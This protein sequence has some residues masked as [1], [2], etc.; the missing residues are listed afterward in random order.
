MSIDLDT[1]MQARQRVESLRA[2]LQ[3]SESNPVRLVETHVSWV[4]LSGSLAYKLKKPLRLPF[5][6]FSTLALRRHF[7]D[8]ELRLNRR[9]APSLYLDVVD[10]CDS[11]QGL[12]FG[13]GG[14]VLD[15]AVRMRR[16]PD[17]ALW[18]EML[19]AGRLTAHHVDAMA[20][21]L[22]DFHRDAAVAIPGSSFGSAASH[23]RVLRGL[24]DATDA[25][26]AEAT[27]AGTQSA[28][29]ALRAWLIHQKHVLAPLWAARLREG[30]VRECHG[31]LHLANVLQ[32]A[33]EAT[34][35][36]GIEFD[37]ELRWIDVLD[38]IAFLAMDLLANDRRALAFRFVNAY[39]QA[40]GDY[41]GL[42]ALRYHMACRAI[43]RA[44][45]IAIGER[46]QVHAAAHGSAARYMALAVALST[47]A[48]AR[49]AI[50][51]GLPGS[52]KSFVSQG[53]LEEGGAI[54]VRSDVERKRFFGLGALENSRGRVPGGIYDPATT[55]RTYA[56]LE[57]VAKVALVA[58][59]P[60]VV[61][62][63]FLRC[64]ERA[65]FAALAES[66]GVP[67]TVFDCHAEVPVLHRRLEQRQAAGLDP[68]EADVGVLDRLTGADEPLDDS[69][70]ARAFNVGSVE[71]VSP[72]TLARRWRAAL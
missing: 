70:R 1:T 26:Q 5:L 18:S 33:G 60:V 46:Q 56:R 15:V 69:E 31:D 71:A 22:A 14:K 29:P 44:R 42:P 66:L 2:S 4:L 6:D 55:E 16:F 9:L 63:A 65:R 72:A 8:E 30:R 40:S 19:V 51:H 21:K 58:G 20:Q 45:V 27:T 68:S 64:S 10:V 38:D 41:A 53:V 62:A 59:W 50:T 57:E 49:L 61:D 28:W 24:I 39:L 7:C 36:D 11:P 23:E 32:L 47:G 17:G 67:F 12:R 25:E 35:F 37:P 52:G 48:D 13:G 43:V 3:A 34:A 54:G